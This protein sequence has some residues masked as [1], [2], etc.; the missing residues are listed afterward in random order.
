MKVQ[1][2]SYLVVSLVVYFQCLVL[3]LSYRKLVNIC[4]INERIDCVKFEVIVILRN[5]ISGML[6]NKFWSEYVDLRIFKIKVVVKILKKRI[7]LE[8]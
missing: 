2:S 3:Y 8:R 5:W 1:F 7:E 6:K 4:L